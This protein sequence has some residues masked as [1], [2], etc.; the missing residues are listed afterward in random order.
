MSKAT[1]ANGE[2]MKT[3]SPCGG[4]RVGVTRTLQKVAPLGDIDDAIPQ[5]DRNGSSQST[6]SMTK[7]AVN[8]HMSDGRVMMGFH[9][10][11]FTLMVP[12]VR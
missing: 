11:G 2:D 4:E 3:P 7:D 9:S 1:K 6:Q 10:I 12:R 8:K 5:G